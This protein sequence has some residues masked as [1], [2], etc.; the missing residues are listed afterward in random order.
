MSF[1][2]CTAFNIRMSVSSDECECVVQIVLVWLWRSVCMVISYTKKRYMMEY[3]NTY[4]HTAHNIQFNS[5]C[6]IHATMVLVCCL[7]WYAHILD[8]LPV[9]F[10]SKRWEVAFFPSVTTAS[11]TSLSY[12]ECISR[13]PNHIYIL[14]FIES[15]WTSAATIKIFFVNSMA[16]QFNRNKSG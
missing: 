14:V 7:H 15:N 1:E 12:I 6:W 9:F 3:T 5:H 4:A 13:R 11:N 8:S 10:P 2:R 16:L